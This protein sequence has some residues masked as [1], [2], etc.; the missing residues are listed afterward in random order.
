MLGVTDVVKSPLSRVN[1]GTDG[2]H[3]GRKLVKFGSYL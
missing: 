2:P 3:S 1:D